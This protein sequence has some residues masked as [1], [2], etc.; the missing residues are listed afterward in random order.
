MPRNFIELF[1]TRKTND[2]V[3]LALCYA[4]K[5]SCLPGHFFGPASRAHYLIHFILNGKGQFVAHSNVYNLGSNQLFIIKPVKP[6]IT[7]Q[8]KKSPG[9]ISGLLLWDQTLPQF[10]KMHVC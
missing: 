5:E 7:L 6:L 3:S 2:S 1:R 9:N 8:M 4:G 10:S